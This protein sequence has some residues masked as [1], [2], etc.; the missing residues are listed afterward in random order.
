MNLVTGH[1]PT[2]LDWLARTHG[3]EWVNQ[4]AL[5]LG[6]VDKGGV[7]CGCIA[8]EQRNVG[9]GE[10]HVWGKVSNDI[11]KAVFEII[12]SR[13]GW[14]RIECRISRKNK[15]VRRAALRWGWK[16]EGIAR[17][18]FAGDDAFQYSMTAS[19]CRWLRRVG[20]GQITESA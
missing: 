18:Y 11:A 2:I 12:F 20:N 4:P 1:E 16:F 9:A 14:R 15:A 5:I 8:L 3:I 17:G 7:L 6:I 10:F 13:I 19:E